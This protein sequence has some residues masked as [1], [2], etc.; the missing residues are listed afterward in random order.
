VKAFFDTN[1]FVYAASSDPRKSRA[2]E[3]LARRG[4]ASAQILNEFANVARKKMRHDWADIEYAVVR[5]RKILDS[6]LPLTLETNA[7]AIRLARDHR[8]SF[9][10][11]LV[12]A[13]ALEAACDTLYSEDMQDGRVFH[14][15]TIQ[16]PFRQGQP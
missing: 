7:A 2:E 3:L 10:D 13:S 8:L 12:V 5:F 9:Y 15:L 1:V 11:A 16:N 4:F 14:G 6:V